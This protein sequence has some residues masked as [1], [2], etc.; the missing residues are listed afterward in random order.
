MG[1]IRIRTAVLLPFGSIEYTRYIDIM[2]YNL[3]ETL[4]ALR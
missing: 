4:R 2:R 3:S 1:D